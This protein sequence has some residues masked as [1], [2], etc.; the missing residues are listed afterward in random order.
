M[1]DVADGRRCVS[2]FSTAVS[3]SIRMS[4][5][6]LSLAC[7]FA[8]A[9]VASDSVP[10]ER[11]TGSVV[12][13][14]APPASGSTVF[15]NSLTEDEHA[16]LR[17]HPVIRVI[18]DPAW[19]PVEFADE[20]GNPMGMTG[21]YLAL[22]EKRLGI[23]FKRVLHLTWQEGYAR[24]KRHEA[25]MTTAVSETPERL[26][27]LAFTQPYLQVPVVVAAQ[28]NVPYVANL[29]ELAGRR[30]AVVD[31]YAVNDWISRD[32]PRIRLVKVK[33]SLQGLQQ[34]QRGEVDGYIDSLLSIGYY[35][36]KQGAANVK[37]AGATP[38]SNT[39]RMA[40]RKD[41]APLVGI[42][43]KA[44]DSISEQERDE[45]FRRWV[46]IRYEQGYDYTLLWRSLAVFGLVILVVVLWNRRL[47]REISKR[48]LAENARLESDQQLQHAA[49]NLRRSEA[50]YRS[51]VDNSPMCIHELDMEGRLL[52]MN[53]SGLL[54]MGVTDQNEIQGSLYLDAVEDA[55]RERIAGLLAK[56]HAGESCFFEFR[57]AGPRERFYQSCFV[58]IR[59]KYD[60]VI[61]LM[62]ISEDITQ[63]KQTQENLQNSV[64]EKT[65][66]L[67]EVHHRVKN[68]L[69][70][71]ASL[72]RLEAGREAQ[73]DAKSV[74]TDMQG[75][76]RSMALLHE[77]LYRTGTFASVDLGN[78]LRE[79]MIQ[80]FKA[81]VD[82][83]DSVQLRLDL[84][85]VRVSMDQALPCGLLVNELISNCLK[86][87]FPDGRSGEV[88]VELRALDGGRQ[89]RLQ[90]S[91]TGVGLPADF[92]SRRGN[93]LGLQLVDD[94]TR[95]LGGTL[96][97]GPGTTF[98]VT[99]STD[100]QGN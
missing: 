83:R 82:R 76:V 71:I 79:L 21:D 47:A 59:D 78:Y 36:A 41:W 50:R 1:E 46:P 49:E 95:Q 92:E 90:V 66:L 72:L 73:S 28:Q 12:V 14:P 35:Q 39:A 32:Y 24:L 56:S 94:L 99:F 75:R 22:I 64:T 97:V 84:D 93:S 2:Y 85:P 60:N 62:G 29:D 8:S 11:A 77:A 58:P 10:A 91:D 86:H 9:S 23:K 19:P 55:D 40:V 16:W 38:Y 96:V 48:N 61:N 15:M 89:I 6:G 26:G 13:A 54:M 81:L 4:L 65:A 74:L 17:A 52:S 53:S 80:M 20:Q 45:I 44:L 63:R 25:D 37:I 3:A 27:F 30:I 87:G 67:L 69:Q 70:V 18:Q 51:L 100:G 31:G 34:L 33:T 7:L 43:Q 68:N 88:R 57:A 42:L 5:A 98:T